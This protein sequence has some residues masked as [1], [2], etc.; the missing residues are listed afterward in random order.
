MI[1]PPFRPLIFVD[2]DE[3]LSNFIG[4]LC[5]LRGV[6]ESKLESGIYDLP[7]LFGTT[8]AEIDGQLRNNYEFWL[9]IKPFAWA[10]PM[11]QFLDG[12]G[13]TFIISAPWKNSPS[14]HMA[15]LDW[16]QNVLGIPGDRIFLNQNKHLIARHGRILI[17]DRVDNCVLWAT[18][19]GA[20]IPFPALHN[21]I[22]C[23][24]GNPLNHVIA[25]MEQTIERIKEQHKNVQ[26]H[27]QN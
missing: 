1:A 4:A 12:I 11:M 13:D 3:V 7:R 10:K 17:D 9:T 20:A 24:G 15:K 22:H 16:C 5:E 6:D 26:L 23:L 2:M 14:C 19:G 18:A 8:F 27:A 21:K 25:V